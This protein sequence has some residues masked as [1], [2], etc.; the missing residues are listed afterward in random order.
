MVAMGPERFD[1]HSEEWVFHFA[2]QPGDPDFNE[3]DIA[4]RI[5]QLLKTPDVDIRVN[6][7]SHWIVECVLANHYGK[8]RVWV[9]GD[10]AHR[11]PPT[12]GLGLNSGIQDAHNLAWKLAA[13]VRG[14][15]PVK[16]LETYENERRP[17]ASRNTQWALLTFMNHFVIE[18]GFGMV[19]GAPAEANLGAFMA[20]L[21]EGWQSDFARQRM[22]EV[23]N[24]QRTEFQAHDIEIG[25]H[26]DSA[27]V[28]A[29]G[30]A[31]PKVSPMGDEHVPTTRPGHRLP[32]AWLQ[33]GGEKVSTHDLCGRGR[34]VLLTDARGSAWHDAAKSAS[35]QFGI[36]V[37]AITVGPGGDC[38]DADGRWSTLCG[39]EAG[40]A[41][42]VRPDV[43]VGARFA[44]APTDAV[45]TLGDALGA[46][47]GR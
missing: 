36:D 23:L 35:E 13:C 10:A 45:G 42:L 41:V 15:A 1:R 7:V 30:S 25:F 37:T 34:W 3:N 32:H 18:P 17:V 21:G 31:A 43:H 29:D 27:A 26:Y 12:T 16:L 19:P 38:E 2:F 47:L 20:L 46:M 39:I 33:R 40:G 4:P 6:K 28:I 44:R 5:K 24:T 9:I 11:H 22:H 8:G 14:Q